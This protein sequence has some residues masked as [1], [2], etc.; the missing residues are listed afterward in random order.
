MFKAINYFF[1]M[2]FTILVKAVLPKMM[3]LSK[4]PFCSLLPVALE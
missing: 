2:A 3:V 4:V 1:Q